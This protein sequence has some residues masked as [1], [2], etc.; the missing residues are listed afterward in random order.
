MIKNIKIDL[1]LLESMLYYWKATSEREKVGEK[2]LYTIADNVKMKACYGDDFN[3]ESVRRALSAISNREIFKPENKKEGR[4][5]NYNMWMLEDLEYTM[6][7]L[8]P[9]KTLN[10]DEDIKKIVTNKEIDTVNIVVIPGHLDISYVDKSTNTIYLNF[11]RINPSV[12]DNSVTIDSVEMKEYI[13]GLIE[14]L[15]K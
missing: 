15:V 6:I 11:F 2:Y 14:N 13:I 1:E 8:T 10:L 7:M 5:W 12:V 9:L 3:G 4:F